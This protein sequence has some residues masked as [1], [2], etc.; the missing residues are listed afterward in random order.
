M[1]TCVKCILPENYPG[2]TFNEEGICNFCLAY[3]AHEKVMGDEALISLLNT[4]EKTGQYDCI[5]P[6]SGGKD[7][8]YIL[9]YTVKKL[10]LRTMAIS[11]NSGYQEKIAEENIELACE[12]LE[13]PLK[14]IHSPGNIQRKLLKISYL[15][16]EKYRSY[17]NACLNCEAILRVVTKNTA[18]K[19]HVPFIMWGSTT[20]EG[21]DANKLENITQTETGATIRAEQ[22][23]FIIRVFNLLF[24][25]PLKI[26]D[27]IPLYFYSILQRFLLGF[28]INYALRPGSTPSLSK[29]NPEFIHFYDYI[30][31]DSIKHVDLLKEKLGWRHPESKDTRFDCKLHC[32]GNYNRLDGSGITSDGVNLCNFIREGKMSRDEA[33]KREQEIAKTVDEEFNALLEEIL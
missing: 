13:V 4:K 3:Q 23:K 33:V 10:G 32:V 1:K 18:K 8:S 9:Y 20:F 22:P 24:K 21:F 2:I 12:I 26:I 19:L 31:W 16:A 30:Q 25:D 17:W 27:H 5:V 11:Y 7:S 28:P 14:I 15:L 6:L 29:E